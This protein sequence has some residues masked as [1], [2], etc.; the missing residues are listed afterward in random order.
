[1]RSFGLELFPPGSRPLESL[2]RI[3]LTPSHFS[4]ELVAGSHN[5]EHAEVR[6]CCCDY[7]LRHALWW[8]S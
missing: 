2:K 4:R 5:V 3:V 7:A 1:M 8:L 6:G